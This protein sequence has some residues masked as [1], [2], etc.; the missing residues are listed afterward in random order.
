MDAIE[1]RDGKL[2]ELGFPADK[3]VDDMPLRA[4][5]TSADSNTVR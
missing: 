2:V 1:R 4:H 3:A 5:E